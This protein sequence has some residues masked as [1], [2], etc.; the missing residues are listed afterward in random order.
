[1][2]KVLSYRLITDSCPQTYMKIAI[3]VNS[4]T[5]G[6]GLSKYVYNLCDV[7]RLDGNEIHIIT[8]HAMQQDFELNL[9]KDASNIQVHQLHTYNKY[10]RYIRLTQLL[11]HLKADLIINNYN[12]PFQY[13]LPFSKGHSKV[14][15]I[16]HN[17]TTDFYR[18]AAI[19][20]K[21]VDGWVAPT[22]GVMNNFNIYTKRIYDGHIV[23]IPHGVESPSQYNIIPKRRERLELIFVGVLYEYK[24]VQSI[25]L[26]VERMKTNGVDFHLSIIGDGILRHKLES[27]LATDIDNGIVEMTG[28]ISANEVYQR[29]ANAHIFLYPTRL[30]SFGLVIAE[31]MMNGAVPVVTRLKGITDTLVENGDSGFLIDDSKDAD[32]FVQRITE[33]NN[34]RTRLAIMSKRASSKAYSSF[35]LQQFHDNYKLYFQSILSK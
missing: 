4:L 17:D 34:D 7:F 11:W 33:L 21:Y 15:H 3:I 9:F 18:I 30:D 25:P 27:Q 24:G 35:S 5:K 23:A 31:A 26:I 6:S 16:I 28:V 20:G 12:A 19:N 8:T 10:V 1:M 22:P 32:A 13:V 29:M 2:I 14:V